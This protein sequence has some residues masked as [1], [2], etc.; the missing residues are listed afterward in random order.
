[1]LVKIIFANFLMAKVIFTFYDILAISASLL[2][3][4]QTT[5]FAIFPLLIINEYLICTLKLRKYIF[6]PF[7]C[8]LGFFLNEGYLGEMEHH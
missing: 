3:F 6:K 1:M 5:L 8:L 2:D 4:S 7:T